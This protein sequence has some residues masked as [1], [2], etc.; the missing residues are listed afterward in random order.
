VLIESLLPTGGAL[1]LIVKPLFPHDDT[2]DNSSVDEVDTA[3]P[4]TSGDRQPPE[5][6]SSD[7]DIEM[8]HC[9]ACRQVVQ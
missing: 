7:C 8:S 4:Q 5:S 9:P 6:V 1:P 2:A 3:E